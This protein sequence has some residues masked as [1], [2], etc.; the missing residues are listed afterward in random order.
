MVLDSAKLAPGIWMWVEDGEAQ[1][2][3]SPPGASLDHTVGQP[4]SAA[5]SR[6]QHAAAWRPLPVVAAPH[7]PVSTSGPPP[8]PACSVRS[9]E[10]PAAVH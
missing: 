2:L 10:S 1:R 6:L 3:M 8:L 7:A 4:H 9:L 5:L